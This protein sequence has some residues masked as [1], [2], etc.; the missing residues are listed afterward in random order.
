MY[1]FNRI[2]FLLSLL[3]CSILIVFPA[4]AENIY[5]NEI[6]TITWPSDFSYDSCPAQILDQYDHCLVFKYNHITGIA[7]VTENNNFQLGTQ[8]SLQNHLNDSE[9]ALQKIPE[10]HV[11]QSRIINDSPLIAEMD[12]LRKDSIFKDIPDL[13]K[14]PIIQTSFI[15]P[16]QNNLYQIFIYLPADDPESELL[17]SK[18]RSHFSQNIIV[19]IPPQIPQNNTNHEPPQGALSLMPKA[20]I[21]GGLFAILFI[22][23]LAVRSYLSRK[24]KESE[25]KKQDA[26]LQNTNIE[27][28]DE[29]E[30]E[31]DE[32]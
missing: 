25:L 16:A 13:S 22:A 14:P 18:L 23:L 8:D 24:Y 32:T 26:S 20:L 7:I 15:I 3:I 12:V 5:N 28:D 19:K 10:V 29:N 30:H 31:T 2:T 1:C 11:M 4:Y 21:F 6:I 27:F 9:N 17:Y